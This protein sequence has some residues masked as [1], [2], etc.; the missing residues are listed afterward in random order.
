[1]VRPFKILL[2]GFAILYLLPI[3]LHAAIW[4]MTPREGN[5]RSADWSSTGMLDDPAVHKEALV[6]IF[7]ARTGRWRGMFAVHSWIVVKPEGAGAYQRYDVLGWGEPVRVNIRPPDG[8]WFGN[9][10]VVVA[11]LTGP[12]AARLIPLIESAVKAYP[13]SASGSYRAWPGP[14]SNTFIASILDA[15][16]EFDALLPPTAIGKDFRADG[17]WFGTMPGGFFVSLG[18]YAGLRLGWRDGIEVN[19]FGAVAGVDFRQPAL[20]IPGFGRIGL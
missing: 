1:M 13:Y 14:N 8:R 19:L 6:Q 9:E 15:V 18:G 7:S 11:R 3:G 10:P 2:L 12:D 5:W 16:P 20:K 4:A 17:R